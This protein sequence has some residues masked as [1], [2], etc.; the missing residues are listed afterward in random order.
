MALK[1]RCNQEMPPLLRYYYGKT[2]TER[3]V[4]VLLSFAT[5]TPLDELRPCL[6]N[7]VVCQ[8]HAISYQD[9]AMYAIISE[10][11]RQFKVEEGQEFDIDYRDARRRRAGHVRSRIGLSE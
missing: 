10:G 6:L 8:K 7:S 3:V 2:T 5:G 4:S 11:G 1:Y 9:S